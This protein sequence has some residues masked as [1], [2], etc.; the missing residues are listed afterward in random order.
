M[1][2]QRVMLT[3]FGDVDRLALVEETVLPQP[4]PGEVRLKVRVT[5]AAFTDVMIRKGLYPDVKE[6]PPFTPGYDLVGIVDALG[7]GAGRFRIGDRVADLTTIGACAEYICLPEDRL[8]AVP[9][10]V[11]DEAALGVILSAVTP[12]QMLHRVAKASSGQSL[13]IHG[14]GGAVGTAM[15]QLAREAGIRA[16]ATDIPAKHDLIRRLGGIPLDAGADDIEAAVKRVA[17]DGVDFVFDPLG[18][19]SLP[20]S[21]HVLKPGGMLVG[22]GFQN[23]VLGRG[24]SIPLDFIR[25]KLWDWL[26][27]GHA[28]AFY[29]I[30][31]MRRAHPDWFREDLS[32]LFGLLAQGR[33]VPEVAQVL[34]LAEVREAHR[35]IESG[36]VPGKLVLRV[37]R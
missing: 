9:D 4:G 22:F 8:T 26:P 17:P 13:L 3:G 35:M 23:E 19:E 25:L 1:S 20:H 36:E 21:L 37:G 10:G 11:S 15:L 33:I 16:I 32:T 5:S 30:G 29:S 24:G 7:S 12:W 6:K 28:T 34:P 2:R 18:G 27:N 14:G 31:A